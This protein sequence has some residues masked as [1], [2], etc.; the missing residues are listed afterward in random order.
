MS[1][2]TP[3]ILMLNS[4]LTYDMSILVIVK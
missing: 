2:L 3:H 1:N 4:P